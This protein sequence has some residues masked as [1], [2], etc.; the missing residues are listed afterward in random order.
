[1]GGGHDDS[2]A[3]SVVNAIEAGG[4]D[5]VMCTASVATPQGGAAIVATALDRWGRIDILIHNAGIVRRAPLTDMSDADLEESLGVHLRGGFHVVRA[6]M[7]VMAQAGYGRIVLTGS[8]SG[9][10]GNYQSANYAMG[11][12]GLVGLCNVVALEGKSFGIRCNVI[13]P[14]AATRMSDGVDTSQFPPMDPELV[15]PMVGWLSHEACDATGEIYIAA[16]GR[17]ARA[18]ISESRGVFRSN[19]TME[20]VAAAMSAIQDTAQAVTFDV[21]PTGQLD[22]LRYSFAMARES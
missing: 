7:P 2:P 8:C 22:H 18:F 21:S 13:A 9:L 15:A 5:A 3:Q 10:Y 20:H 6:A 1:M 19:W 14:A 12:M 11:K 17:M 4:G 16:A